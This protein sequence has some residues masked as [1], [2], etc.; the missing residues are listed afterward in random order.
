VEDY[1]LWSDQGESTFV[2]IAESLTA[3]SYTATGLTVGATYVFKV[4]SRNEYGLSDYSAELSVLAAQIPD[5]PSAPQT[6]FLD[7]RVRIDWQQPFE[8]GSPITG[9]RVLIQQVD[10][11][12]YTE[13]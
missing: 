1:T 3:T 9:Y 5:Q 13:D 11:T 6:T 7:D 2:V 12:T 10:G 8:Q 4:Q